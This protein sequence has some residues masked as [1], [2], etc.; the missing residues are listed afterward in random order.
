MRARTRLELKVSVNEAYPCCVRIDDRGGLGGPGR[1]CAAH[2]DHDRYSWIDAR[3]QPDDNTGTVLQNIYEGLVAWHADGTVA[4]MLAK[5]IETSADGRTYTF[6]LR[7][8]V[9]S[10]MARP[11][12]ARGGLDLG[13]LLLQIRLAVP[14]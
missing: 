1:E 5:D 3:Q 13:A 11:E 12:L 10:T 14:D 2:D 8:G 4:P 7:D 6:T 9:N